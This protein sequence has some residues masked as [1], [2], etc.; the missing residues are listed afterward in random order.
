[1]SDIIYKILPKILADKISATL[2]EVLIYELRLRTGRNIIAWTSNGT[3]N[4][5]IECTSAYIEEIVLRSANYSIYSINEQLKNGYITAL[6]GIRIGVC[7]EAI[8]D[9]NEIRTINNISSLN[10][11]FAHEVFGCADLLLDTC[12]NKKLNNT[13]I[14]SPPGAGKTTIIRDLGRSLSTKYNYNVLIVDERGEISGKNGQTM[15][16]DVGNCDVFLNA[17]KSFGLSSAVRCMRPDII[18]CDELK[19]KMDLEALNEALSCGVTIVATIHASSIEDLMQKTDLSK[20]LE[21]KIFERYVFLKDKPKVGTINKILD[22][23]LNL[24]S[25]LKK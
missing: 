5:N 21:N 24:L 2:K 22:I 19:G 17:P 1:M 3:I 23:N 15:G 20:I 7:G 4:T 6:N 14:L 10:I 13:L 8:I 12:F 16:F 11:R 9:N 25:E 18:I